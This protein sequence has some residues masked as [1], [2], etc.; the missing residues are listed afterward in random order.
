[1]NQKDLPE[2]ERKAPSESGRL[3]P[4]RKAT[5]IPPEKLS[6]AD[7]SDEEI[8]VGFQPS[9]ELK[10]LKAEV[11]TLCAGKTREEIRSLTLSD[12]KTLG[13]TSNR[14]KVLWGNP[15]FLKWFLNPS[16]MD[17]RVNYL[18]SRSLD[19]IEAIIDGDQELYSIRDKLSAQKQLLEI[20]ETIKRINS[21]EADTKARLG[22]PKMDTKEIAKKLYEAEVAKEKAGEKSK[23]AYRPD[24]TIVFPLGKED[25]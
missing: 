25:N 3:V 4:T 14:L 21:S 20:Y 18:L 6:V 13:V 8:Q 16:E 19:N 17:T 1:M 15:E 12:I 5:E 11:M 24:V 9:N 23:T 22:A 2:V 10:K 7:R